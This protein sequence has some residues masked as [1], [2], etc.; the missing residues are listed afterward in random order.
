[1]RES[2]IISNRKSKF[3]IKIIVITTLLLTIFTYLNFRE[4][5]RINIEKE[6]IQNSLDS[7]IRNFGYLYNQKDVNAYLNYMSIVFD[8]KPIKVLSGDYIINIDTLSNSYQIYYSKPL[9]TKKIKVF[10]M[11]YDPNISCSKENE[12]D[13]FFVYN[14]RKPSIDTF[15]ADKLYNSIKKEFSEI[16]DERIKFIFNDFS[17]NEQIEKFV[18]VFYDDSIKFMCKES[19]IHSDLETKI[20]SRLLKVFQDDN[21]KSIDFARFEVNYGNL[22]IDDV[23]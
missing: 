22:G 16:K 5:K 14:N 15:V 13:R 11:I 6:Q 10:Q 19:F 9:S 2:K 12:Y 8:G 20:K 7:Y 3:I 18:F 21:Y 17:T 4:S 23:P 1:M